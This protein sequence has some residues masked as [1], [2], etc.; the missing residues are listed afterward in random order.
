M[1]SAYNTISFGTDGWRALIARD[2]TFENVRFCAEG[3]CRL[4]EAKG[5]AIRGLSI[6]YDC[7]WGSPEFAEE[8]AKVSTAHGIKTYLSDR[9]VPTPVLSYNVLQNNGAAAHQAVF[10]VH[11]HIIPRYDDGSGLGL[12][13]NAG[14]T[15]DAEALATAIAQACTSQGGTT[16]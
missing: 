9:I 15:D 5:T 6:G 7:R 8:V 11:V 14:H 16:S 13:W 2:Y 4:L 12:V 10:H 1:A 3:V